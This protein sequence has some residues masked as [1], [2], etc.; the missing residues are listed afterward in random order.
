MPAELRFIVFIAF[1]FIP[2][3]N[4]LMR[5]IFPP[6]FFSVRSK[7]VQLLAGFYSLDI[8]LPVHEKMHGA[9]KYFIRESLK[10]N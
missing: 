2:R 5:C 9:K 1:S 3:I 7:T 8:K 10:L 4:G 6:F